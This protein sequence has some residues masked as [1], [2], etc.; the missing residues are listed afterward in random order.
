MQQD[1]RKRHFGLLV[2]LAS[3]LSLGA[4][5]QDYRFDRWLTAQRVSLLALDRSIGTLEVAIADFRGAQIGYL[6]SGQVPEIWTRR[7]SELLS[8]LETTLTKSKPINV[9]SRPT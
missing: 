5:A 4:L 7:S 9:S 6:A 8:A 3:V 2:V 1:W